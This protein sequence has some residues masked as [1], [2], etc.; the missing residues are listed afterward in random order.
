MI[1]TCD[2]H[3]RSSSDFSFFRPRLGPTPLASSVLGPRR[4]GAAAM[5]CPWAMPCHGACA[6]RRRAASTSRERRGRVFSLNT[7]KKFTANTVQQERGDHAS[8]PNDPSAGTPLINHVH[9]TRA[10]PPS[11]LSAA[12]ACNCIKKSQD[13]ASYDRSPPS[14]ARST[15]SRHNTAQ[16]AGID[17]TYRMHPRRVIDS[18]VRSATSVEHMDMLRHMPYPVPAR[19][20]VRWQAIR[21]LL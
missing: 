1:P 11:R 12:S 6:L 16:L 2:E 17:F 5:R 15:P 21:G 13:H 7:L 19:G 8:S 14:T 20:T 10:P 9:P 18:P 4:V 3:K